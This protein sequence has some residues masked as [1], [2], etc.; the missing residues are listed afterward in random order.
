MFTFE[1]KVKNSSVHNYALVLNG[2][3]FVLACIGYISILQIFGSIY[4]AASLFLKN[5]SQ[6]KY[7]LAIASVGCCVDFF[8][9]FIQTHNSEWFYLRC[10]YSIIHFLAF[11]SEIAWLLFM[12]I[13][14]IQ[15][16]YKKHELSESFKDN[17]EERLSIK[18]NNSQKKSK[19]AKPK[20]DSVPTPSDEQ[21]LA[22]NPIHDQTEIVNSSI[23]NVATK[24]EIFVPNNN[25]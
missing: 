25:I 13:H 14:T 21:E 11:I 18:S 10:L 7:A 8:S 4:A 23:K 3:C 12:Y 15:D 5:V 20:L 6:T 24:E 2:I 9:L 19:I 16:E 22:Y 17:V 1:F